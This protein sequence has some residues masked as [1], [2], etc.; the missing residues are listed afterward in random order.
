[1]LGLSLSVGAKLREGLASDICPE[2][3][4]KYFRVGFGMWLALRKGQR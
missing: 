1:V 2:S 3:K 4:K